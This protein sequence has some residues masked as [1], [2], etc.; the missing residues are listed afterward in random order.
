MMYENQLMYLP[1]CSGAYSHGQ[2]ARKSL[3]VVDDAR[4]RLDGE[5]QAQSVIALLGIVGSH[6]LAAVQSDKRRVSFANERSES[7]RRVSFDSHG[8][9]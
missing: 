9:L 4:S 2:L 8:V 7:G 3:L 6:L 1:C 5:L